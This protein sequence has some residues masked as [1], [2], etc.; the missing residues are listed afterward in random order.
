MNIHCLRVYLEDNIPPVDGM[1]S[2]L[3]FGFDR[4]YILSVGKFYIG[5]QILGQGTNMSLQ[6]FL[7]PYQFVLVLSSEH[8]LHAYYKSP[9]TLFTIVVF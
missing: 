6:T 2:I 4:A 5:L 7:A 3:K 8:E 1:F 9:C